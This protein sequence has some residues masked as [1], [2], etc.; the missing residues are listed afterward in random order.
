[1]SAEEERQFEEEFENALIEAEETL[2]R[3]RQRYYQ[4]KSDRKELARLQQK[5]R[6]LQRGK[7]KPGKRHPLYPE[8]AEIERQIELLELNL[9][10]H[11]FRWRQLRE[12]FWMAIRFG[13]LGVLL[14]L[15]LQSIINSQ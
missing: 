2:A 10:S 4:V 11:L 3:L 8:L 15:F 14:G 9:E 13:G 12:P 1:M 5:M 7:R 6:E